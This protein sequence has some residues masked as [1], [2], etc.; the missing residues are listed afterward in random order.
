VPIVLIH[1]VI[2]DSWGIEKYHL[3]FRYELTYRMKVRV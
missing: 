2:I 3:Q 1:N